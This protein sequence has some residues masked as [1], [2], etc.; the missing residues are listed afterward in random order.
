MAALLGTAYLVQVH[1]IG[2]MRQLI[3]TNGWELPI[4]PIRIDTKLVQTKNKRILPWYSL[5]PA[6]ILLMISLYQA[7][8]LPDLSTGYL[9][10]GVSLAIFALFLYLWV[11][12]SRLPVRGISGDSAIDQHINDLTKR[13]WSLLIAVTC[14]ITL[15]LLTVP[16]ASMSATGAF[17]TILLVLFVVLV[18]FL[19]VFTFFLLLD[20]RKK[21]DQLLEP[22][23]QPR[24][25]GED[26]YWR[27]GFYINPND[28]R[29][30]VPDRV[31]MNI[32]INLG[33]RSGQIVAGITAVFLLVLMVGTIIPMYRLDFAPDAITG[34][35]QGQE[36]TFDAPMTGKTTVSLADIETVELIEALPSPRVRTMGVGTASY[37]IGQFTVAGEPARMFVDTKVTP[38]LKVTTNDGPIVFYTNKKAAETTDLY[39]ELVQKISSAE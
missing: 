20:L 13:Y 22:A 23:A 27:Y 37:Q 31:G 1:Y 14:T 16:L 33:K 29:L 7:W 2:K 15:L 3:L 30:F 38:I 8:Q 18:V 32:G 39:E 5:V 35:V 25:Y 6:G 11:I 24:Y 26:A 36:V 28:A 19:I 34:E 10:G 12:I 17:S 9:M 4:D 21:Q